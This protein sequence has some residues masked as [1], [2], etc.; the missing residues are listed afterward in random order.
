M[1]N[2]T[3]DNCPFC[4]SEDVHVN[5][6]G[7]SYRWAVHCYD[8][9]CVGPVTHRKPLAASEWNIRQTVPPE[10]TEVK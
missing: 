6:A 10:E 3:L 8:C 7:A 5:E 2:E 1:T 4:Y 9:G